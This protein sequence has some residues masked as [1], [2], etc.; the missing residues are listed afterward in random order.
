MSGWSRSR[1]A[2]TGHLRTSRTT[3]TATSAV[4]EQGV[5]YSQY[6]EAE[7]AAEYDR[8]DALDSRAKDL[9]LTS[10][11]F[12]GLVV[13]LLAL[14]VGDNHTFSGLGGWLVIGALA[15]FVV[16]SLLALL[17]SAA[18]R[19]E[20]TNERTVRAMLGPHWTDDEVD[21]R[22][23]VALLNAMT[24]WTLR[25]GNNTKASLLGWALA[26]QVG[27]YALLSSAAGVELHGVLR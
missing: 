7:L 24:T 21:A 9:T 23:Q 13:A 12:I 1:S 14:V 5:T 10:S 15:S 11:A 6:V 22:N 18:R 16:A 19:F 2:R 26:L 27:G 17:A 4:S 3:R 20:V 25:T 8:R